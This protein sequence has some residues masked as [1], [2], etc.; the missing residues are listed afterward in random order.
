MGQAARRRVLE[1]FTWQT[2]VRR[3]LEIYAA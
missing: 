1:K 3:C 2:V